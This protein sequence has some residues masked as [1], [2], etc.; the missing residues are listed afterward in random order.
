MTDYFFD[1]SAWLE[2][3]HNANEKARNLIEAPSN[4]L[5]SSTLTLFEIR[6]KLTKE[7]GEK[8]ATTA[9]SFVKAKATTVMPNDEICEKAAVDSL[10]K[11]LHTIDAIIYRSALENKAILLTAD[12]DFRKL[13]SVEMI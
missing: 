9:I 3:F 1:S 10:E 13:P 2:Y 11:K 4:S 8:K 6:K 12:N 7:F 5:F